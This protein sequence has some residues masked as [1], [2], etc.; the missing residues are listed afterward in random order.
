MGRKNRKLT[1]SGGPRYLSRESCLLILEA[2]EKHNLE[3]RVLA[4]AFNQALADKTRTKQDVG[5]LREMLDGIVS[6][7]DEL[8]NILNEYIRGRSVRSVGGT[9]RNTLRIALWQILYTEI[10]TAVITNESL[11]MVRLLLGDDGDRAARFVNGV[12]MGAVRGMG[13]RDDVVPAQ[14]HG[15][16]NKQP[17]QPL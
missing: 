12:L 5:F 4:A 3:D 13:L 11:N 8:D 15:L 14:D 10:A 9:E 17:L 16:Q 2:W 1:E 7:I 6:H